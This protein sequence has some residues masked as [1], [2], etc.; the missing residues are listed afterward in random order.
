MSTAL[1]FISA[2]G[3]SSRNAIAALPMLTD[4]IPSVNYNATHWTIYLD[5]YVFMA[6]FSFPYLSDIYYYEKLF[7]LL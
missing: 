1:G 5:A 3:E 4:V 2:A 7:H 6:H